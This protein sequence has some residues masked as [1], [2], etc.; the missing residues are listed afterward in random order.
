[1]KMRNELNRHLYVQKTSNIERL[2]Y[3]VEQG[4]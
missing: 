4:Q 3:N 1:M 2:P